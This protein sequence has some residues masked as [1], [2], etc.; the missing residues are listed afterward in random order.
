MKV[1]ISIVF[2]VVF[3]LSKVEAA[4]MKPTPASYRLK[5]NRNYIA[6]KY[7]I[8]SQDYMRCNFH[9][10]RNWNNNVAILFG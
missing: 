1:K 8:E 6:N 10:I 9:K 3:R 2:G 7:F 4:I 5:G